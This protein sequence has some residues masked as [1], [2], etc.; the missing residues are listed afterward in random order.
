MI[1]DVITNGWKTLRALGE[2]EGLEGN[3]YFMLRTIRQIDTIIL[4]GVSVTWRNNL[5]SL[6]E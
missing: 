3:P 5:L 4:F 2:S 6:T 1:N